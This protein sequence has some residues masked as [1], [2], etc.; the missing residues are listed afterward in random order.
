MAKGL[1]EKGVIW[2]EEGDAIQW[3]AFGMVSIAKALKGCHC[4]R[5]VVRNLLSKSAAQH[6]IDAWVRWLRKIWLRKWHCMDSQLCELLFV[7]NTSQ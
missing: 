5:E 3:G 6:R 7:L 1:R 4:T 2:S